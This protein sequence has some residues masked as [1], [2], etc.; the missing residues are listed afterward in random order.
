M[1]L[2]HF[3]YLPQL[4]LAHAIR[5]LR[6][7]PFQFA[8]LAMPITAPFIENQLSS[9]GAEEYARDN[10]EN[11]LH[12]N[13]SERNMRSDDRHFLNARVLINGPS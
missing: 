6:F 10:L 13:L 5:L 4:L 7:P 12:T 3:L 2:E 11:R 9:Q 1:A 8:F